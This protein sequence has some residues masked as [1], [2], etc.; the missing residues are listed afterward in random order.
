MCAAARSFAFP[1]PLPPPS[2]RLPFPSPSPSLRLPFASPSF[3]LPF[4][5]PPL[6]L[7]PLVLTK[8]LCTP[9]R[10]SFILSSSHSSP[11]SGTL[12][13]EELWS[14]LRQGADIELAASLQ[15]GAVDFDVEA[16]NKHALRT[17]VDERRGPL[18]ALSIDEL[19]LEL[20]R[21][22]ARISDL[23]KRFDRDNDGTVSKTEFRAALPLLGFDASSVEMVRRSRAS[24]SAF[25]V[26]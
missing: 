5:F 11:R 21:G 8:C 24:C 3:R 12:E 16:R 1:S 13:Y 18:K 6:R 25:C 19:R 10:P 26:L 14:K 20:L 2:L 17:D 7:L 15:E 4:P 9:L 22:S 23:L